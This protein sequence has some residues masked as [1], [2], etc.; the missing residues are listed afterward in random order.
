ML[1]VAWILRDD[2]GG[3]T[4]GQPPAGALKEQSWAELQVW[5]RKAPVRGGCTGL[6]G[7]WSR[8]RF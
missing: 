8:M 5:A 4:A 6:L 7:E 1:S 2:Y 3:F